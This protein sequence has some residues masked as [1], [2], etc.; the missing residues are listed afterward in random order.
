MK[1]KNSFRELMTAAQCFAEAGATLAEAF[2][3]A[4][5]PFVEKKENFC[6]SK[7]HLSLAISKADRALYY[8]NSFLED[9]NLNR[10]DLKDI[11]HTNDDLI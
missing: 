8:L 2:A 1:N 11:P 7:F 4:N 3:Y 5:E 6:C 9:E 10:C